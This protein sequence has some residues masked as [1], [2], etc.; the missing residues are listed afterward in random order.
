MWSEG[1]D[2]LAAR[3]AAAGVE[4][5]VYQQA[6]ADALGDALVR[7]Y[8]GAADADPVVLVGFSFGAD[9]AIRIA[10]RLGDA[11][12]PVALLVT[13]DPVTPPDVPP[14]VGAC[15]NF[16]QSNGV[17]D[18]FPWLRGVPVRGERIVNTNIRERADLAEPG[19]GHDT[20][21]KNSK[22]HQAVM[23]LVLEVCPPR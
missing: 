16:Y 13:L 4:A 3:L 7:T 6:Q 10:R 14:N 2:E 23:D 12:R 18:A 17:W 15:R 1:M 8:G 22:V 11:G 21:A 5:H 9:E 20:L 19:T